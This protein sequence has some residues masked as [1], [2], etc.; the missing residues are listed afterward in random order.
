MLT[1]ND[2]KCQLTL[3]DFQQTGPKTSEH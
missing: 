3:N 2:L 1:Q